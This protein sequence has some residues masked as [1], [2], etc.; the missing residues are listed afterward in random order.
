M[1]KFIVFLALLVF[2]GPVMAAE[3][4]TKSVPA[5][6]PVMED[7][8]NAEFVTSLGTIKPGMS[9]DELYKV[10]QKQDRLFAHKVMDDQWIVFRDWT[11][12]KPKTDVVTFYLKDSVVTGWKKAFVPSAMNKDSIYEYDQK[13][14]IDKWFFPSGKARWDGENMTIVEWNM[15]TDTQKIMFLTEYAAELGQ[16]EPEPISIDTAKYVS[17]LNHF[18]DTCSTSRISDKIT[19]VTRVLLASEDK[20]KEEYEPDALSTGQSSDTRY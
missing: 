18:A 7:G 10:F 14:K 2:I 3:N 17:A 4:Q 6:E 16:A 19:D 20:I 13:E 1:R 15:L 11:S 8:P 5:N 12:D 9:K